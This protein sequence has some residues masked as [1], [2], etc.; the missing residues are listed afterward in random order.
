M[1]LRTLTNT[2]L[3]LGL[4]SAF[5]VCTAQAQDPIYPTI[6]E[7]VQSCEAKQ[8]AKREKALAKIDRWS[9]RQDSKMTKQLVKEK[10]FDTPSTARGSE[11]GFIDQEGH[12]VTIGYIDKNDNFRSYNKPLQR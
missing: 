6:R 10:K 8:E 7:H 1:K 11:V 9:F 3:S 12:Y 2:A 5:F 4:A